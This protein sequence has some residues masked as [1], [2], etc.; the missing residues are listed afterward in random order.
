MNRS[1]VGCF[2]TVMVRV[3][4]VSMGF[5][6]DWSEQ[7]EPGPQLRVRLYNL[8]GVSAKTMNRAEEEARKILAGSGVETVWEQGD[9]DS[10]EANFTDQNA[11]TVWHRSR[12]RRAYLAV[13]IVGKVP[14]WVRPGS[15]GVAL[16]FGNDGIHVTVFNERIEQFSQTALASVPKLLGN[17]MAHEIGHVLLES[18]EHSSTG[19]MKARWGKADIQTVAARFLAFTDDQ[20]GVLRENALRRATIVPRNS[21]SLKPPLADRDASRSYQNPDPRAATHTRSRCT[22][23]QS[24]HRWSFAR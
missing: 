12:D 22:A 6:Q 24:P 7:P 13:R 8:A 1:V 4:F 14:N 21:A 16:P 20:A 5:G 23:S 2:L 3:G 10:S 18:G 17:A 9:A 11:G 15:L 19:I